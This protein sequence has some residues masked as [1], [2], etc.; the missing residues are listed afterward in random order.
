MSSSLIDVIRQHA[1]APTDSPPADLKAY[2]LLAA[3]ARV[4]DRVIREGSGI[5]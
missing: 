5:P 3:L 4:P 2:G 1:L